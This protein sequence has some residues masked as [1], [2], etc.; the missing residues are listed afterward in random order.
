MA[1]RDVLQAN[2]AIESTEERD[3]VADQDW[4]ASDDESLN[5]SRAQELLDS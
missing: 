2:I 3:S 1:G 5:E 4:N